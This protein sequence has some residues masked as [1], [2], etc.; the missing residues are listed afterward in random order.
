MSRK[1]IGW[2]MPPE[3]KAAEERKRRIQA[4]AT[5]KTLDTLARPDRVGRLHAFICDAGYYRDAR[6]RFKKMD[7]FGR[8]L[9]RRRMVAGT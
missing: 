8:W 7:K 5:A 3:L 1:P 2:R 4:I 9:V 6:G